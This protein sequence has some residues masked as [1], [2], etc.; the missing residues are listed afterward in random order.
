MVRMAHP[1][2][3][4][5]RMRRAMPSVINRHCKTVFKGDGGGR[6]DADKIVIGTIYPKCLEGADVLFRLN[7]VVEIKRARPR[8]VKSVVKLP[9]LYERIQEDAARARTYVLGGRTSEW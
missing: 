5:E 6:D 7:Q 8:H 3:A 9:S 1:R 2:F 4:T